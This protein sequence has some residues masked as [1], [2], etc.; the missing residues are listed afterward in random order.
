MAGSRS[1]LGNR[2]Q[3]LELLDLA[4]SEREQ[5]FYRLLLDLNAVKV[6]EGGRRL[7]AQL[8][9]H[10][11]DGRSL[12]KR[13]KFLRPSLIVRGPSLEVPA[14][15]S[16]L[17]DGSLLAEMFEDAEFGVDPEVHHWKFFEG[18]A[19]DSTFEH[20]IEMAKH[21]ERKRSLPRPERDRLRVV[22][23]CLEKEREMERYAEQHDAY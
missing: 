12:L 8:C 19:A 5:D 21:L 16:T 13:A 17:A 20:L 22:R 23:K 11:P 7:I 3:V 6:S 4:G 9:T 14:I 10:L 2:A 1:A 15:L 18:S